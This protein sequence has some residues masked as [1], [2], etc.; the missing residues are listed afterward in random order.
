[1]SK[2]LYTN[3]SQNARQDIADTLAIFLSE[4]HKTITLKNAQL[5]GYKNTN[6]PIDLMES[7]LDK[8]PPNDLKR[9][10]K[11]ALIHFKAHPKLENLVLLH[12][13]LHGENMAYDPVHLKLNGVFDFSDAAI[14][15]YTIDFAKLFSVDSDLAKRSLK[16]YAYLNQVP[17]CIVDS[18]AHYILSRFSIILFSRLTGNFERVQSRL[19]MLKDFIST[20]DEINKLV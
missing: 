15:N 16:K 2:Q 19:K 4:M 1:L 3:L 17:D 18:A 7:S 5:L 20:W 10:V 13:D 11:E 6:L 8:L 9:I 14:G 12:N